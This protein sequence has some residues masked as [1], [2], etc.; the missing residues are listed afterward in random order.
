MSKGQ[1]AAASGPIRPR[2]W[3]AVHLILKLGSL[4][5]SI[6]AGTASF[7]LERSSASAKHARTRFVTGRVRV[8]SKYLTIVFYDVFASAVNEIVKYLDVTSRDRH[9]RDRQAAQRSTGSAV[10]QGRD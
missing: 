9:S 5:A 3:T 6:S 7:A 1:A 8:T 10:W 2:A 4:T